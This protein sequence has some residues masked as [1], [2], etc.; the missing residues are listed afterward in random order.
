MEVV[1]DE[2]FFYF[3]GPKTERVILYIGD[4][5]FIREHHNIEPETDLYIEMPLEVVGDVI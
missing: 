1:E 5:I 2:L 3:L 4:T